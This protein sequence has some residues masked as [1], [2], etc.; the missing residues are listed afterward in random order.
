MEV[1]LGV[2]N[3]LLFAGK[4]IWDWWSDKRERERRQAETIKRERE[5]VKL[6]LQKARRENVDANRGVA[7][8]DEEVDRWMK[9]INES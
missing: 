2:I 3:L 8:M 1:A 6:V 4:F 7:E 5:L 9:R